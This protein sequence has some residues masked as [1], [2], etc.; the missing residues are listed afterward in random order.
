MPF[1]RAAT[2]AELREAPAGR[3]ASGEGFVHFC[4]GEDLWGVLLWGR[5]DG[6]AIAQLVASLKLEIEPTTPPHG[7]LVD[8]SRLAGVDATAFTTLARYVETSQAGLAARVT[9]LALV[10]PSGMEGALVSGFFDVLPRPY[11]VAVYED[12]REA[13]RWLACPDPASLDDELGAVLTTLSETSPV[14]AQLRGLLD[15]DRAL[16]I[17]DAAHALALSERTLQRRLKEAGTTFQDEVA[18]AR[19]RA[20]QRLL[21]DS[22]ASLTHIALEVGCA[23]LQHF[24]ALFRRHFGEAPSAW[25][26]RHRG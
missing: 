18:A 13:L 2:R 15:G 21:L 3:Y 17:G 6:E 20:A 24:S 1:L 7:S 23:S 14:V 4:A 8:A 10:R 11:P 9:R 16:G 25:R 22:D 19:L 12:R 5:P 26:A